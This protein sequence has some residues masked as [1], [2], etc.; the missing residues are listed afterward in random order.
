MLIEREALLA[1]LATAQ[2]EGGRL[3]FVGGEAGVGKTALVRGFAADADTRVL[4]GACEHLVTPAPLGPIVDIAEQTKGSLAADIEA[5]REP[6]R[7]ALT[8]LDELRRPTLLVVEDLHWADEA[9]LDALRLVGRRIGATPSLVI[10]TYRDEEDNQPLRRLLGDLASSPDVVRIGVPPLSLAGV[11]QLTGERAEAVHA[12]TGGNPFFVT[13]LLA[14]RPDAVPA[15]VRD[16]VLARTARLTPAA[17]RL[18]EGAALVPARVELWLLDAAFPDVADHLDECVTAGM[19]VARSGAVAFRHELARRAVESTVPPRR[20][21][22]LHAAILHALEAASVADSSRLAHHAEAAGDAAAILGYGRAAAEHGAKSGAHRE[23][24]AQYARVLNLEGLPPQERAELLSAQSNEAQASGS[25][26]EAVDTLEQAIAL[27]RELGDRLR[28]GEH[29]ARLAVPFIRLGRNAEADAAI[30]AAVD[31]LEALPPSPELASTYGWQ[32]YLRM[33]KRDNA[34]A[35]RSG[36]NA[37]TL[38]RE[39]DEPDVLVLGLTMKGTAM[40]M[41]GDIDGGTAVLEESLALGTRHGLE[42]RIEHAMEMLGS[43]LG[44][45][46]ELERAEHWLREHMD[47]GARQGVDPAYSQAWLAIVRAY[48]GDWAEATDLAAEMLREQ[49]STPTGIAAAVALGRVRARRGDPGARAVLDDALAVARPGGHLQRLGHIY[50][51]PAEAAWLARDREATIAEAGAVDPLAL[52]KRHLWF[53]GEL[54][55]W[56]RKAGALDTA[57]D[58]IAEPYRLQIAGDPA[59][60]AERCRAHGCPYEAARALAESDNPDEVTTALTEFERLG[61]A[62][63]VRLTRERLRTLGAPVPRGPRR[64]T[65]ANPAALTVRELEVLRLVA[66]GLRNAE[67]ADRLVLSPRTVDHHVAAVLRKLAARTRGEAVAS[68]TKLGL[69]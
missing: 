5:G 52:E 13:E 43:G 68:A 1:R 34:D 24:A 15:T 33:I 38:A 64:T 61:A 3:V 35:V 19:L 11:R 62:P 41:G 42:H 25:Y 51:A 49:R 66:E 14:S 6:R 69:V 7:V 58:W 26:A 59:R 9:T 4:E 17:R 18:L 46:Y 67:I 32:S 36:D 50:A 23:A 48:R 22:D 12:L 40:L 65:R 2:R 60:A 47:Y 45:M 30:D 8:L 37:V 20:R 27:R 29:L 63:S 39:L 21:R 44:E 31:C 16:A 56:Q 54:A 57:P 28:E 55:S 10:A 53:A